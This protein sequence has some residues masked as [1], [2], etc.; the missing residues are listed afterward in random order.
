MKSNGGSEFSELETILQKR[1]I[2]IYEEMKRRGRFEL[3]KDLDFRVTKRIDGKKQRVAKLRGSRVLVNVDAVSLPRSAIKYV[4]AHEVAHKFTKRHSERFWQVVENLYPN[5]QYGR[6][7]LEER[8]TSR[9][10]V[11]NGSSRP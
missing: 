1:L 3:S 7:L 2:S 4:I 10:A 6:S 5:Y 11:G 8:F 9:S